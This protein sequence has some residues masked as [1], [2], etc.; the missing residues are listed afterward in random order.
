MTTRWQVVFD[1]SALAKRYVPEP[2]STEVDHVFAT[3]NPDQMVCLMLGAGEVASVLVRHRN[4][5]RISR[6]LFAH[7]MAEITREIID[8]PD[9]VTLPLP[10]ATIRTAIP[11]LDK[12]S[13]NITDAVLLQ[14]AL[15]LQ[16]GVRLLGGDV[17]LIASDKGL[18]RAA[19]DEGIQT[20]DPENET[21][22]AVDALLAT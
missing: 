9:F 20:F 19:R 7:S 8:S 21:A 18:L 6:D 11:F 17:L 4:R 14:V 2:G 22:A 10:N 15:D 3:V 12:H 13:V 1:A 16:A 5:G